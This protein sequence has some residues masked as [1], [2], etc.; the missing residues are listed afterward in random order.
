[1]NL[2]F[3]EVIDCM[4]DWIRI[5]DADCN[6]IYANKAMKDAFNEPIVG[7]KCYE[8]FNK[9]QPCENCIGRKS[10]EDLQL[11]EKEEEFGDMVFSVKSTPIR[12]SEGKVVAIVEVLRDIT[13][14][15]RMQKDVMEQNKKLNNDL[16]LARKIQLSMLPSRL[17][18]EKID[19]AYIYRPSYTLGG[20]LI[21]IFEIDEDRV[22]IYI[23]DVSGHGV[24]S[25]LLT[26]FLRSSINKSTL[27]PSM[28]LT[29][30]YNK[31][32]LIGFDTDLYITVFYSI[33]NVKERTFIYSNAGHNICPIIYNYNKSRFDI[34]RKPGIP[35]SNWM[36]K[37]CYTDDIAYLNPGDRIFYSSD[38]II[39]VRNSSNEQFSEERLVEILLRDRSEPEVVLNNILANVYNFA[40][41][42][43]E[44]NLYDDIT[45]ALAE[46]K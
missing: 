32:N 11:H 3:N 41:I 43:S 26:I 6:I 8:V 22:G 30:L 9:T 44:E 33:I 29:D 39:E 10:L 21:D 34:L 15:K 27:S 16:E 31:F 38:G 19:I 24:S 36:D 7:K 37:P 1:M 20:D 13:K 40:G 12:D 23:A 46:I 42:E 35:I 14:L 25:S 45:M 2:N 17:P 18:K 5:L 4:Y 28:A